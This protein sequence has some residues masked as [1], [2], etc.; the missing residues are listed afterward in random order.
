MHTNPEPADDGLG[1]QLVTYACSGCA[2]S[3]P[4]DMVVTKQIRFRRLGSKGNVVFSKNVG[5]YCTDCLDGERNLVG[6]SPVLL[7]AE[8]VQLREELNALRSPVAAP[9]R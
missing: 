5:N 3:Y 1:S 7:I 9:V 8:I 4:A 6:M 2:K